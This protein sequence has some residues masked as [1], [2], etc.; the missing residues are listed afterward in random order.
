MT[1]QNETAPEQTE[2]EDITPTAEEWA[3]RILC[4]D[5][6]CIGVI[7]PGGSCKECGKPYEGEIPVELGADADVFEDEPD[8]E[9]SVETEA[10]AEEDEAEDTTAGEDDEWENRILC[11]DGNC[12]GVIGPDGRCKECGKPYEEE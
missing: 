11:S 1:D 2:E 7:G 12:I 9:A 4:S 3:R 5:G 10:E 6:N 8:E